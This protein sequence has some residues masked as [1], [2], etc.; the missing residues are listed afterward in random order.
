[1]NNQ[2]LFE[3]SSLNSIIGEG[4]K[5]KGE[6]DI[7]GLLRIDGDFS[8]VIRSKDKVLVGLNGRAECDIYASTVVV[9]G[10]V[11]GNIFASE[12]VFVLTTGMILGNINTPRLIIEEGVIFNGHCKIISQS[13]QDGLVNCEE[14]TGIHHK[15]T[16][17]NTNNYTIPG[18]MKVSSPYKSSF[19]KKIT[20]D[21]L[22]D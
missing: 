4:T 18:V 3:G 17:H 15:Y 5:F 2:Q 10:V 20:T 16:Y 14:N 9:G 13:E 11:R 8:G 21:N 19:R 6:F 22:I 12:K 7:D 1:M